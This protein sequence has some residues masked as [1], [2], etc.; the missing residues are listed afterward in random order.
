[1]TFYQGVSYTKELR[2]PGGTGL[3][4]HPTEHFSAVL[5]MKCLNLRTIR[6]V[7]G[8]SKTRNSASNRSASKTRLA[9]EALEP[10]LVFAIQLAP[11]PVPDVVT[12][13]PAAPPNQFVVT[14]GPAQRTTLGPSWSAIFPNGIYQTTAPN[15]TVQSTNFIA[16]D[17]GKT[18]SL[19]GW[20]R[21]GDE[22]GQRFQPNNLQSL[23]YTSYDIDH[24]EILPEHVLRYAGS[25]DT[26][27]ATP[28]N[29]G[30]TTI[31]LTSATG[32]SNSAGAGA[33]TRGIAWYGYADSTSATYADYTYTRNVALGDVNGLWAPGAISGNV[34]QLTSPWIGPALPA[35]AAVRDTGDGSDAKF[36]PLD[37]QP[38]PGDWTWTQYAASFGGQEQPSGVDSLTQ[39]RP[40]TAFIRPTIV[41][42]QQGG[43]ANF[44][45]WGAVNVTELPASATDADV[46]PTITDLSV[47]T[48]SDQR[49]SISPKEFLYGRSLLKVDTNARYTISG[50]AINSSQAE[51][52]PLGLV[53]FDIDQKLIEPLHVTKHGF[54]ADTT[55]ASPLAPGD[56]SLLVS[57]A[58]GWSNDAW[59]S[60]TTRALAWYGY[61][62]STGHTYADYTYTRNIAFDFDTGLWQPGAIRYD[63]SA[64]AY[65]INLIKPW[66]GPALS[67][68]AAIRNAASGEPRTELH[69]TPAN[70]TQNDWVEYSATV[71]GGLWQNGQRSEELFR[72]G[73]AYIQP[74]Y[75][76]TSGGS[77]IIIAPVGNVVPTSNIANPADHHVE[78]DLE[79][80]A[81]NALNTSALA[82]DF[83]RDTAV[84]TADFVTWRKASGTTGLTPFSGADANGDGKVDDLDYTKWRSNAFQTSSIVIDSV[85]TPQHGTANVVAGPNG[86]PVIHYQSDP[87][88]VGTDVVTYTLRNTATNETKT[89][90]VA[91]QV[92][93]SNFEQ[94][95]T[96]VATL[97]AQ[98]QTPGN[99]APKA[100]DDSTSY[101]AYLYE[102][103]AGVPIVADGSQAPTLLA[104]D[105]DS[106]NTL[107]TRLLS[108]PTHGTLS[109]NFDGTFTYTPVAD[110]VGADTFRYEA[111]DGQF[112]EPAVASISV[113][114]SSDDVL[115]DKISAV[116][117]GMLT[118]ESAKARFPI[119]NTPSY[120]DSS[121]NSYLSWRVHI[122]PY[123]GMQSLYNQFH[124]NEPWD[125][126]NNLPLAAKMPDIFRH[127]DDPTG[128]ATT[129]FS[130]ISAEGAPYYWRRSG[131]LLYGPSYSNFS[132][133]T[134]DTLL[135]A[136]T[137]AD[138]AVAWTKPDAMNFD[139]NNPLSALGTLA[140][141]EF[142]AVLADGAT[143]TLPA[144]ID[145]AT[146]K[147]LVT[148]S[149]GESVDA[150]AVELQY[151]EATGGKP[152][153]EM[154]DAQVINNLR[155]ISIAMENYEQVKHAFP[156][157]GTGNFDANGNAYL[158]WRVHILPYL[159][160]TA[161][162]NKFHLNE[163]WNSPNN[164]P[165]LDEMPASFRSSGDSFDSTTTRIMTFTGKDAPFGFQTAGLPQTG[166]SLS[167]IA[168][169]SSQTLMVAEAGPDKAVPWTS[170]ADMPF[171]KNNPFASLGDLS[172]GK[173]FAGFFDAHVGTF[174]SDMDPAILSALVTRNGNET[175]D[176]GTVSARESE[177]NVLPVYRTG[178]TVN[179]FK[180]L[181]IGLLNFQNVT[182]RFPA[183]L[184]DSSG[185]PLL[186]WRVLLLPY[187]EQGDLYSKFHLN[188]PWDSPN[189]LALLDQMPDIFRTPG[190]PWDT[191]L[192]RVQGFTGAN[193][194]FPAQGT[195]T[196]KGLA[197]QSFTDGT[198]NTISFVESG[199]PVPW[200]KPTDLPFDANNP[201]SPLGDLGPIFVAA[202]FDGH[203]TTQVASMSKDLL[204][205]YIT[206][207]G[208]ES[209]TSPPPIA[210]VPAVYVGQSNGDAVMNEFG[211]DTFNVV[212]EKAP[213]GDVVISVSSGDANIA[214]LDKATLTFTPA[215]W[216]VA[217]RVAIRAVDNFVINADQVVGITA[218]VV[219]AMSD[220]SYDPVAPQQFNATVRNDDFALADYNHNGSAEQTDYVSWRSNFG[221]NA[222]GSLAADGNGNGTVD[223]ADYVVWRKIAST[224][225]Q[226]SAIEAPSINSESAAA[227]IVAEPTIKDSSPIDAAFAQ[228]GRVIYGFPLTEVTD[229]D[230]TAVPEQDKAPFDGSSSAELLLIEL[231][232]QR[233]AT[234]DAQE[235]Q[236]HV[237]DKDDSCETDSALATALNQNWHS[238]D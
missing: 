171:D 141:D 195:N 177:R 203:I 145:P 96:I 55:L 117:R 118:Y 196:T 124:L 116:G 94:N 104:N 108:A 44:I 66:S 212:L 175:I 14:T 211:V 82:G 121:G 189:N 226:G 25:T 21:S 176:S 183:S 151:I 67:A 91:V 2:L 140:K 148:L 168:D 101:Y 200:T 28:L 128:S 41:T 46:G 194:P 63:V 150:A 199:N 232:S 204:K 78:L 38:V 27:L 129:R 192:T 191:P 125:S 135:V 202:F 142:Q 1:L 15:L 65:R 172:S 16:V 157:T 169:G 193:A 45:S 58:S 73:T 139:P 208:G 154:S 36:I 205:A 184:F 60:A 37:S 163:P 7:L 83:N 80:L 40:G 223:A 181:D 76:Y 155:Q 56:T 3:F 18:Y 114:A 71:G 221:G 159:G 115:Q 42:N 182:K 98:A 48:G 147:S 90:S 206:Y 237:D 209:V 231:N 105:T 133:G 219:A 197:V 178:S 109:L 5:T 185:N 165:L 170:P 85:A 35:G 97:N 79:V 112:A 72:P 49:Q 100:K 132:D 153:L 12:V 59:E 166:P 23:G 230:T 188:E 47:I 173:F 143:V 52:Y 68:G 54:A 69:T 75:T 233:S 32:W 8:P 20:A 156:I 95:P 167:I 228:M 201:F 50:R 34:I 216:N 119:T 86:T 6:R 53:S 186:S 190:D 89:L 107:V 30:D 136:E 113:R 164:L 152:A 213:Q 22:F 149:G 218:E 146:F 64:G 138:K 210:T 88:F 162:Y 33:G 93:G 123:L 9:I 61:T 43:T 70:D 92:L 10:R 4:F 217:Q 215:N 87:W 160:E 51:E 77:D 126:P 84:D 198:S 131:G 122:L 17:P 62:D 161:L 31:H 224:P 111:F 220:D 144:S 120:F 179:D 214:T 19:S 235:T 11:G 74:F 57:N 229:D 102:T 187:I 81:K 127:P 130:I 110:F 236:S 99:V 13:A 225:G 227:A 180:N 158:S 174:G 103:A 39:F 238:F 24:Q 222:N 207:N 137:G 26:T 29:P 106:G 234:T 134:Q